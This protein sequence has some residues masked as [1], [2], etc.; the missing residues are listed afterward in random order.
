MSSTMKSFK[1]SHMCAELGEGEINSVVTVMGWVNKKRE[2]SNLTFITL[3]DRTGIVQIVVDEKK[4]DAEIAEKAASVRSEFVVAVRGTVIARTPENVNPDMKTGRVEIEA[5]EFV[6]LSEAEVPPFQIADTG[7]KEDLRLKYRYL[8]LRRPELQG[9]IILRHRISQAI[10]SFLNSNGFIDIETPYLTKSTPEGARDYLVPSRIHNGSFY[11]LPQSPQLLKQI[12][13]IS[14]FDRYYQITRCFRDEDLRADRQPEFTQVDMELSFVDIEDVLDVNER[15]M[16]YL[17]KEILG[18][19]ISVPFKRMTYKEAMERFGSDK[20][21]TRFGME[22]VNVS[23]VEAI[24][25]SEFV[26]FKNALTEGGSVRGINAKGCA[27]YTRKQ[28]DSLTD[29]AKT[30]KAKGLVWIALLEDGGFKSSVSKFFTEDELIKIAD[31][32]AAEKGDLILLCADRNEIVLDAL[33]NLRLEIAARQNLTDKSDFDFLWVTEFP[34]LEWN[35]D[36]KRFYAKHHPFTSPMDEDLHFFESDPSQ[37]RSK[38]YDM[39]LNGCEL[40]GGSIRIYQREIQE[41]MFGILGFTK[42]EAYSQFNYLLEAFKYGA[43]PHGGLAFGLDRICMLFAG[44]DAIRDVIAF[45]KVK[46]ASCPLTGAPDAVD[47]K[48]LRELGIKATEA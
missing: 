17:M 25:T 36:E 10:R 35:E 5:S 42:E 46:D 27:A 14:G 33:G 48:Q 40:G 41:K 37:M 28:T 34:L 12:L 32:F 13:M 20:P 11:A 31:A 7:V 47:E 16:Q 26:V 22:L 45:P 18:K 19:E 21:D 23:D 43:P 15:L 38:A 30:Y 9:S 24:S 8:D 29:I 6:I 1:R 4:T 44:R 2:L 39:V 3:R